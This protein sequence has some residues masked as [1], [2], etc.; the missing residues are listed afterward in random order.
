MYIFYALT[1]KK[2]FVTLKFGKN[3][4][5]I[6]LIYVLLSRLVSSLFQ[7]KLVVCLCAVP[8]DKILNSAVNINFL[9]STSMV[10][11]QRCG[12]KARSRLESLPMRA[13]ATSLRLPPSS[14][15][16][17]L[18]PLSPPP[19]YS[20]SLSPL[21]RRRLHLSSPPASPRATLANGG[22]R[23]EMWSESE[24][25]GGGGIDREGKWW[26]GTCERFR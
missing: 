25:G 19:L 18:S 12:A 4:I 24:I 7:K 3:S 8:A 11:D 15:S 5:E 21:T 1:I 2:I 9:A 16:P 20:P 22:S 10:A 6:L 26:Q 14:S 13:D 23:L 17:L